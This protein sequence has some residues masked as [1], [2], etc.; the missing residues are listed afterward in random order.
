[1]SKEINLIPDIKMEMVRALKLRNFIFFLC[2]IVSAGAIVL[3]LFLG[4]IVVAQN[5]TIGGLDS[6]LTLAS[7]TIN[8][9]TDLDEFLTVQNQLN[10]LNTISSR[11]KVL[12]RVFDVLSALLPTNGDVITISEITVNMAENTLIFDA[13][14]DAGVEPYI[15][16]RVLE[17]FEKSMDYMRYDYGRY[18][19][20]EGNEIPTYCI[21]EK[22]NDGGILHDGSRIYALWTIN[23]DGCNEAEATASE[24]KNYNG[25]QMAVIWRTP[26]FNKWYEDGYMAENGSIT[27]IEH[28]ESQCTTYT[29]NENTEKVTWDASNEICT[30]VDGGREGI[31]VTESSNGR[32][33]NGELV[34]RF[35]ATIK[36]DSNVFSFGNKHLISVAPSGNHNVTDS[37]VQVQNMFSERAAD[38]DPSDTSCNNANAGK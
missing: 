12:S 2:I 4:G 16:Y 37:Y 35:S 23:D 10:Q 18:V 6:S 14:A 32:N 34:L 28:F 36:L 15:D 26:E 19:D 30:M 7:K 27:G 31:K 22:G 9:Y 24:Y 25:E 8:G 21:I 38:C 11:K 20:R 13:Q 1:M 33:S 17:A 29:R 3:T 5:A